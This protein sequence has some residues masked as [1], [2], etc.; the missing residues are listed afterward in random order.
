M[1]LAVLQG[2]VLFALPS[3]P[4]VL[5]H[6]TAGAIRILATTAPERLPGLPDIPTMAEAGV[7]GVTV[8]DWSGLWAPANTRSDI[9]AALNKA[10]CQALTSPGLKAKAA[11]LN[12]GV[13]GSTV[14]SIKHRMVDDLKQWQTVAQKANISVKL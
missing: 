6:A 3:P 8:T 14:D 9:V 11:Q 12:L 2:E 13:A 1:V 7:S 5:G 4:P 10:V